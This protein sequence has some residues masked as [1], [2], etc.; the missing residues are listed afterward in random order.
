MADLPIIFVS[1]L[2]RS[3]STL[4]L[5]L[6]GQ[7]PRH[8][9]TPTSGLVELVLSVRDLWQNF[10]EFRSQGLETVKPRIVSAIGGLIGG[11][12]QAEFGG[13]LTVFDKARGWLA[14]IEL[15][16]QVLGRPVTVL[17]TVRDVRAIIASYEKLYQRNPVTSKRPKDYLA[18]QSIEGRAR[19]L[20]SESGEVGLTITRLRD[21]FRRRH[22]SQIVLVPYNQLCREP[23]AVLRGLHE[24]LAL[25]PFEYDPTNVPQITREDDSEYG[26]PL[27]TIRNK[28]EPPDES[29]WKGVLPD[30]LCEQ[31]RA[32]YRDIEAAC[33]AADEATGSARPGG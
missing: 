19:M 29:P 13:G 23:R 21:A 25:P 18:S 2:P 22:R 5:N 24:S 3:G 7:N 10:V 12:Y 20:L 31:L 6:L 14:Y 32:Q 9:V 30:A 33:L 4:L 8:H 17:V 11:F 16:E 15:L 28:V 26:V 27:H 1:G